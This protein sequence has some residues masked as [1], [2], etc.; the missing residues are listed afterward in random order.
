M[1]HHV[2]IQ[3]M[4]CRELVTALSALMLPDERPVVS[5]HVQL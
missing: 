4:F 5:L 3:S 2:L 1:R